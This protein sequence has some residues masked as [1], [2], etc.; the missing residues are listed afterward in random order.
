MMTPSLRR[1]SAVALCGI[2][3]AAALSGV[4]AWAGS[5]ASTTTGG[6]MLLTENQSITTRQAVVTG[7]LGMPITADIARDIPIASLSNIR[8]A[9]PT[10]TPIR[11][12][13][14]VSA[15]SS[16]ANLTSLVTGGINSQSAV[17]RIVTQN[18]TG[19]TTQQASF[20]ITGDEDRSVSVSIPPSVSL[21]RVGGGDDLQF[22]T[23]SSLN[24]GTLGQSRLASAQPGSGQLAFNVGG[25]V[26]MKPD[27]V[28]GA[29]AGVLRVTVQYN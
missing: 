4:A 7:A 23:A 27:L 1:I 2:V 11:T 29:Y 15:I 12:E 13:S 26:E 25:Q 6:A 17:Q 24:T 14:A 16:G 22:D 5:S 9:V 20:V 18:I 3:S 19:G 28:A 21:G 8:P 10:I